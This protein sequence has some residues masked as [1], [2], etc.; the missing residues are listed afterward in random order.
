MLDTIFKQV[1]ITLDNLLQNQ[2]IT[3]MQYEEMKISRDKVRLDFLFFLPDTRYVSVVIF[4]SIVLF[5]IYDFRMKF[6]S[7]RL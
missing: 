1:K 7:Y 3:A 6:R 4:F 2:S 5:D